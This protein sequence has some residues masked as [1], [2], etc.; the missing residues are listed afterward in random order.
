MLKRLVPAS[1]LFILLL[2]QASGA[3][4]AGEVRIIPDSEN[5]IASRIAGK[6][7]ISPEINRRVSGRPEDSLETVFSIDPSAALD[8]P[9]VLLPLFAEKRVYA[10]GT[11]DL[12]SVDLLFFL[13]EEHGNPRI[14]CFRRGNSDPSKARLIY[15]SLIPAR[16]FRKDLLFL[17]FTSPQDPYVAL[18]RVP[19]EIDAGLTP[20]TRE[21]LD[22][23]R[24]S[25]PLGTMNKLKDRPDWQ[26]VIDLLTAEVRANPQGE[27]NNR[28]LI[29]EWL[30]REHVQKVQIDVSPYIQV[31][32]TKRPFEQQKA[33]QVIA[34][35][36][37]RKDLVKG[38]ELDAIRA[39]I[40]L[41]ASQRGRVVA[42]A[43]EALHRLTG[44]TE[45]G[46]DPEAWRRWFKAAYQE[47]LR[48]DEAVYEILAVIKVK[49]SDQGGLSYVVNEVPAK[50]G[51]ELAARIR[52][53]GEQ[54]KALG[55]E[56]ALVYVH[57]V[58]LTSSN[59]ADAGESP[60]VQEIY[61]AAAE[62]GFGWLPLTLAP[63]SDEFYPFFQLK[64]PM[65]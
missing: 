25:V 10:A 34:A 18:E 3:A 61:R 23:A 52:F 28:C 19:G 33:A 40:P 53:F 8:V 43:L 58:D 20:E 27:N 36:A 37:Q 60:E 32:R 64:P 22:L 56:P 12:G 16:D 30:V 59:L 54:A 35:V 41:T 11:L 1:L 46:R 13:M 2:G 50:R 17:G 62:A 26:Q 57:S 31:L 45:L 42:G 5:I 21:L 51:S 44:Q 65:R 14:L 24:K 9:E 39:L 55:L 38:K 47:D 7:R 6:W 15:L 63:P 48:L 29:I 49:S 4:E